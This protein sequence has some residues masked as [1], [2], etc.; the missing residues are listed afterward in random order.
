MRKKQTQPKGVERDAS[1]DIL[2]VKTRRPPKQS[3][4]STNPLSD[5]LI[6]SWANVNVPMTCALCVPF[7]IP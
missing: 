2:A 6:N 4:F 1:W 7:V 3:L 5:P